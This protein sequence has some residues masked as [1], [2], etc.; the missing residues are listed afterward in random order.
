MGYRK[1]QFQGDRKWQQIKLSGL[2]TSLNCQALS[3][4]ISSFPTPSISWNTLRT[5]NALPASQQSTLQVSAG[6]SA[7]E[8]GPPW[9]P[10]SH[11]CLL[12]QKAELG[13]RD[14]DNL[15]GR[16]R[17]EAA[18]GGSHSPSM[19]TRLWV[20]LIVGPPFFLPCK[21]FNLAWLIILINFGFQKH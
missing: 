5:W 12:L 8:R 4:F 2:T 16:N 20:N 1:C 9:Q 17:C 6:M 10:P 13:M 7:P 3:G 15:K 21:I 18:Q 14:K 19:P 11:L